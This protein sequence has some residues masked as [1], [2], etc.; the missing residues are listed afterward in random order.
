VIERWDGR[1]A[2][3]IARVLCEDERYGLDDVVVAVPRAA[4]LARAVPEPVDV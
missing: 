4:R 1:A 2:E 3:R